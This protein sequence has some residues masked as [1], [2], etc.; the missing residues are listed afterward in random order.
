MAFKD[1][2]WSK[3]QGMF[4]SQKQELMDEISIKFCKSINQKFCPKN[5]QKIIQP[6]CYQFIFI[7]VLYKQS[8]PSFKFHLL[9]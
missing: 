3:V 2:S 8:I 5:G 6:K 1:R 7:I 9:N 4:S